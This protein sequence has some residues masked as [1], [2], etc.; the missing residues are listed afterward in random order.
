MQ[1]ILAGS[2]PSKVATALPS[3]GVYPFAGDKHESHHWSCRTLWRRKQWGGCQNENTGWVIGSRQ[4]IQTLCFPK[5]GFSCIRVFF[6]IFHYFIAFFISTKNGH[7]LSALVNTDFYC[8]FVTA[9]FYQ[10]YA[11]FKWIY[12]LPWALFLYTYMF[13]IK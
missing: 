9:P 10:A 2:L 11:T 6:W 12:Q 8:V 4:R 5:D 13:L 7:V 3:H 1:L